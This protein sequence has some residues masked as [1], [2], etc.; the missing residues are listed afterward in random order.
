RNYANVPGT[1]FKIISN[2]HDLPGAISPRDVEQF[3]GLET[4]GMVAID[5]KRKPLM[6]KILKE[7]IEESVLQDKINQPLCS[8]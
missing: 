8:Y 6:C 1:I 5:I 7:A 4:Y 3:L 2:K